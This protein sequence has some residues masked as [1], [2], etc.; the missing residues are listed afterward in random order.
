MK[1]KGIISTLLLLSIV[2]GTLTMSSCGA[3]LVYKDGSFYCSKNKVTYEEVDYKYAPVSL[4]KE[5]FAD[6]VE[7]GNKTEL[8]SLEN[9]DPDKWLATSDGRLFCARDEKVPSL[10]EM[11]VESVLICREGTNMTISLAEITNPDS[12]SVVLE[13]IM[14]SKELEYPVVGEA[15][16]M[17]TLR[18]TSEKYPWLYYSLS[19]I[20]FVSDVVICDYPEK[21]SEYTYREVDAG[22]IVTTTSEF[23]CWYAV[24]N[25][26]E[27][28]K[29]RKIASDSEIAG[30]TV[31][32]PDGNGGTQLYVGLFFESGDSFSDCIEGLIANYKGD[33]TADEIRSLLGAPDIA[34]SVNIVEYNYGKYLIY[35]KTNGRCIKADPLIH[36]Y[37]D[38]IRND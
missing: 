4:S 10:E 8:F 16:E 3:R 15:S 35:D 34:E 6:L 24:S 26:E 23:E 12:V 13:N 33:L 30:G 21:L 31:T 2:L 7:N 28:D 18:M 9:V 22:V 17:L 25:S 5:K 1:I 37:K 36:E 20:E 19:Y 27:A 32:K 29:L 38:L 14:N 11:G